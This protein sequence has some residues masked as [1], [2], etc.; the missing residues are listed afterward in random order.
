VSWKINNE[1]VT[2]KFNEIS[3]ACILNIKQSNLLNIIDPNVEDT[4]TDQANEA[5]EVLSQH[6]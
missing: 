1:L 4:T 5:L 2:L 6:L 3:K